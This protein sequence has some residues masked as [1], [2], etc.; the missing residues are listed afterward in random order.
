MTNATATS[1]PLWTHQAQAL[2]FIGDKS[3]AL[4]AMDMGTGKSFCA[5][6]HI[7][8]VQAKRILILAPLSVVDH[9]WEDQI[10][11]HNAHPLKTI[12]L[13]QRYKHSKRK[14]KAAEQLRAGTNP[15]TPIAYIINY[16][17]MLSKE[18]QA[19]AEAQK[20]DLIILDE[21]HKI[22]SHDGKTSLYIYKLCQSIP[23]RLGLTGT[24][25]PHSPMDI[26]A[27]YRALD[28]TIFGTSYHKFENQYARLEPR[29]VPDLRDRRKTRTIS[30]IVGFKNQ[31]EM[32]EK[33]RRI[34]FQVNSEDVLD[35][36]PLHKT[37]PRVMMSAGRR[38]YDEMET[39]FQ[40]ELDSGELAKASNALSK[41]LRLQQI[42]SGFTV[43]SDEHTIVPVD[44]S[45]ARALKEILETI[46]P[47][48]P[49]V[50]FARFLQDLRTIKE[51][52]TANKTLTWEHSGQIKELQHWQR[53][54]GVIAMQIQAGGTGVDL[55]K[56][57][58]CIYYSMGFSLGEYQQ[59][60]KRLHRPGQDRRVTY[61]H[62]ISADTVD[63]K[64]I[65][66]LEKK[67]DIVTSILNS[68]NL[69]H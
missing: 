43:E 65:R 16:E 4:L 56:A 63:E 57:R 19:W 62:L 42:T 26:F 1:T 15:K 24:P 64:V 18:I 38:V 31:D 49:V 9:V 21:C 14:I 34:A 36:P 53:E 6:E 11:L 66:S 33:F 37:Y 59:S 17:S 39:S 44:D 29:E 7:H 41:L 46:G 23:H 48:E 28:P 5:I 50:V 40:A 20:F 54:G 30:H 51:A 60:L 35:L 69:R 52:A 68:K 13:G 55:T 10:E 22:K 47:D 32:E 8:R 67:E 3:G 25:M 27:Q 58:Y 12:S 61:V 2:D 45:K